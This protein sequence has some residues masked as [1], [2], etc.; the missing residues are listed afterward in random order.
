[1]RPTQRTHSLKSHI[2]SNMRGSGGRGWGSKLRSPFSHTAPDGQKEEIR[3]MMNYWTHP[4]THTPLIYSSSD[5]ANHV[6]LQGFVLFCLGWVYVSRW[7]LCF[8]LMWPVG[9]ITNLKTSTL[10][11]TS[12]SNVHT[13]V[14]YQLSLSF[15]P[16]HL[17]SL[18]PSSRPSFFARLMCF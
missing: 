7:S 2:S 15:A 3:E 16:S 1:M 9:T 12:Q 14:N 17:P 8:V 13:G 18:R 10:L 11:T 6:L 5:M 4:D